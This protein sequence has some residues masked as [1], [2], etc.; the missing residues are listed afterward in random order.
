MEQFI[1]VREY[2]YTSPL[3]TVYINRATAD[4]AFERDL[5]LNVKRVTLYQSKLDSLGWD[6]PIELRSRK[7]G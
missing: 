6:Q 3:V 7:V 5:S 4:A 2:E 1:L